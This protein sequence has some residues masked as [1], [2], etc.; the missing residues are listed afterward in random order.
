MANKS[1]DGNLVKRAHAKESYSDD[2][3]LELA[4]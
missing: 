4:K 2:Q 3:L 1:L